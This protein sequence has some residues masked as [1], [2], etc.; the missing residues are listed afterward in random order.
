[1]FPQWRARATLASGHIGSSGLNTEG[2]TEMRQKQKQDNERGCRWGEL[3][4]VGQFFCNCGS[5]KRKSYLLHI[6]ICNIVPRRCYC[7]KDLPMLGRSFSCK[8]IRLAIVRL[9]FS[10]DWQWLF[11]NLFC[12]VYNLNCRLSM[13]A[14]I[15]DWNTI[16]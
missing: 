6:Y 13:S 16:L 14:H 9:T 5:S 1:M 10:M 7:I 2:E 4:N 15:S 12:F 8:W 11:Q 3:C